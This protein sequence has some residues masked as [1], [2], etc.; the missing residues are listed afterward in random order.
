M[1]ALRCSHELQA[2]R[3][4]LVRGIAAHADAGIKSGGSS[5]MFVPELP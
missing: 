1:C 4:L 3:W 2:R 5:G